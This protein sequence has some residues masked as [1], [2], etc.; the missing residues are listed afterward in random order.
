M[1]KISLLCALILMLLLCGCSSAPAETTVPVEMA[2]MIEVLKGWAFQYNEGTNDYSVFFGLLDEADHEIAAAVD[3][4]VRIVNDDGTEVY[5]ATHSVAEDDFDAYQSQAAGNQFL[6]NLRIPASRIAPGT[7]SSGKV[8]L[9]VYKGD[10][11][12]FEEVNCTALYCLPLLDTQLAAE[13]LPT[14]LEVKGYDGKVE[15]RIRIDAV[16]YV[17]EK[18]YTS[19][20]KITIAGEKTY[21]KEN[22][23]L[24]M[25][26]YKIYDSEG[27]VVD[28]GTV[29]LNDLSEGDKFKDDSIVVYDAVPG[30]TYT[31]AFSE[32]SW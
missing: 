10:A 20:L 30:E 29:F 4:D 1:K 18:D 2:P 26:S 23:A 3:V 8:Y 5:K 12:R 7:A 13:G 21:G 9:T 28:S 24:D 14:E 17:H 19:T 6:A 25:L 27:Y 22:P 31:I 15:S 11:V 16:S 32:Y